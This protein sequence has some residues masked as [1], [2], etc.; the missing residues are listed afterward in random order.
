ML[1]PV[2][3]TAWVSTNATAHWGLAAIQNLVLAGD[4]GLARARIDANM[5]FYP[6]R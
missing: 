5:T 6:L 2:D 4:R 1:N 3:E